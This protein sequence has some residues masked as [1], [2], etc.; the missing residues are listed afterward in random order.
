MHD[1]WQKTEDTTD[2]VNQD[3]SVEGTQQAEP[4]PPPYESVMMSGYD[5]ANVSSDSSRQEPSTSHSEFQIEVRDPVKHGE[6]V[7]AHVSYKVTTKTQLPQYKQEHT[8]VIRRFRDFAWLWQRLQNTNRGIIVPPLPEKSAV[9]KFQMTSEFIEQ[10]RRALQVFINRVAC[11]PA[12]KLNRD[13]QLFLETSEDE[14]AHEVARAQMEQGSATK[15]TLAS[16]LQL[17]KDIG[18]HT[19]NLMSG[20]LDDE[21]EDPDY[22]KVR[23]YVVQLEA[24]LAEVHRQSQRLIERQSKMA[25]SMSDF[26][27]SMVALGRFE[28]GTLA[29][30]FTKLGE[31]ADTLSGA[32]QKQS[33]QLTSSFEAPLK[34]F[35]RAV[36]SAKAVMT[37]RSTALGLLQQV[38]QPS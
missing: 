18:H 2:Y 9:Q 4:G 14:F 15:K 28:S 13:L 38:C 29:Q 33:E 11:H 34:E 10:R 21:E 30:K 36:K 26:G 8:E 31:R 22:I 12:L 6:G 23:D 5:G 1:P 19:A 17:F 32:C 35:V 24:H 25:S 7:S 16:T 27:A 37:D 20:K 3:R